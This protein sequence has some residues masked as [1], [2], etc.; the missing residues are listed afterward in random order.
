M[1]TCFFSCSWSEICWGCPVYSVCAALSELDLENTGWSSVVQPAAVS[2][3]GKMALSLTQSGNM[4]FICS[5]RNPTM[6]SH[7]SSS[8]TTGLW[9]V[10]LDEFAV[11]Q[12]SVFLQN[13]CFCQVIMPT[14]IAV[15]QGTHSESWYV[16]L[17]DKSWHC[18][19][20]GKIINNVQV[21]EYVENGTALW[22]S[23][24]LQTLRLAGCLVLSK[25]TIWNA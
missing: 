22:L 14:C 5:C 21:E 9:D 19:K 7:R 6:W 13:Y 20:S 18:L 17:V 16:K 12:I 11:V 23:D 10:P 8:C 15:I 25:W 1:H 24:K 3:N 2:P 4:A